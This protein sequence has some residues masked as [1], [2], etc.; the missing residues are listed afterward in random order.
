M[1]RIFIILLTAL[2]L[3]NVGGYYL[4]LMGLR[5]HSNQELT[6]RLDANR[7]SKEETIELKIPV[8]LPYP[9]QQQGF[10]R[11]DGKFEHQG[12]FY[13]F[14]KQKLEK[15]TLYIICI[16]NDD[17]KSLV[18]AFRNYVKLTVDVPATSKKSASLLFKFIKD[19]ESAGD[20]TLIHHDGWDAE[21]CFSDKSFPILSRPIAV[22]SPPPQA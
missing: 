6:A 14:V 13:K 19:Y 15:D 5:H 4:L 16:R 17:E 20:N 3:F 10:Q 21:I 18:T 1:K 11:V 2:F 22:L 9:L 12:Q 8:T 7:Y